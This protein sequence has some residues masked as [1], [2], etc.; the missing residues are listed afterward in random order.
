MNSSLKGSFVGH[1][2]VGRHD[3]QNGIRTFFSRGKRRQGE[4]GCRIAPGRFQNDSAWFAHQPQ[5]FCNNEPVLFI[6]YHHGGSQLDVWD[7][8]NP[9]YGGLQQR[10]FTDKGQQ[11]FGVFFARKRPQASARAT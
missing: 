1:H 9:A 6:A 3:Q 11:L 2:M 8:F 10:V 4:G 7:T 5:L